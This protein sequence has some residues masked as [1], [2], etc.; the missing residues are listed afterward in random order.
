MGVVR[1]ASHLRPHVD[2]VLHLLVGLSKITERHPEQTGVR[3]HGGGENVQWHLH[4]DG[5]RDLRLQFDGGR[6]LGHNLRRPLLVRLRVAHAV[7][8]ARPTY[9]L[10]FDLAGQGDD[11]TF[12]NGGPSLAVNEMTRSIPGWSLETEPGPSISVWT[13][14]P[15]KPCLSLSKSPMA[16]PLVLVEAVQFLVAELQVD[17]LGAVARRGRPGGP[18]DRDDMVALGQHPGQHHLV[19]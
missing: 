17:C 3:P 1:R 13:P 18:G 14:L 7:H 5:D 10:L 19:H 12:E 8:V 11:V 6:V 4:V 9:L 2:D 16:L 15:C